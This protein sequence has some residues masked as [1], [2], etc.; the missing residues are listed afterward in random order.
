[1]TLTIS[2]PVLILFGI[3]LALFI[4][5]TVL[6]FYQGMFDGGGGYGGGL[7][8]LFLVILYLIFWGIPSLAAWAIWATWLR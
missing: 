3:S 1:M 5:T 4:G 7:G 2:I 8:S 6:A